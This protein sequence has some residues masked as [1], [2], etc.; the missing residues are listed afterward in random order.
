[1]PF[2]LAISIFDVVICICENVYK[3]NNIKESENVQSL[4]SHHKK[5]KN[6]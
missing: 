5:S 2:Y 6:Y 4:S 1:M 3:S